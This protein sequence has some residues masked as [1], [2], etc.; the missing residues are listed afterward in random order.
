MYAQAR[1]GKLIQ[2]TFYNYVDQIL[3]NFDPLPPSSGQLW[4]FYVI[5]TL[6]HVTKRELSNDPLTLFL[7]T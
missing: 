2:G 5:P 4:K 3:H 1:D 7:F 6:C